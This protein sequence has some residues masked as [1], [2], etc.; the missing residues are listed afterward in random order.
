MKN[1]TFFYCSEGWHLRLGRLNVWNFHGK[2]H[3]RPW[4]GTD[5][6]YWL[7]FC[8]EWTKREEDAR[9]EGSTPRG[10]K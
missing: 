2:R 3:L 4:R 9:N 6:V 10:P 5:G 8:F 7:R 1:L